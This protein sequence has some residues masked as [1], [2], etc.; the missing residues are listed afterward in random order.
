MPKDSSPNNWRIVARSVAEEA[1][2]E[3]FSSRRGV[4]YLEDEDTIALY[5]N[6]PPVGGMLIR[7]RQVEEL[8]NRLKQTGIGVLAA[9]TYPIGGPD[10]GYTLAIVLDAGD[11]RSDEV[12]TTWQRVLVDVT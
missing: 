2:D 7:E 12:I 8:T 5:D 6:N 4:L 1:H 9:A 10:D 11:D 3:H